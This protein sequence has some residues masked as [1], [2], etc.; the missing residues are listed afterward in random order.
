MTLPPRSIWVYV[1]VMRNLRKL[2]PR[3]FNYLVAPLEHAGPEDEVVKSKSPRF[4]F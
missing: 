2:N 4:N 1:K 3:D